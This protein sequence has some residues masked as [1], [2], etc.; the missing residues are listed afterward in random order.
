MTEKLTFRLSLTDSDNRTVQIDVNTVDDVP[1]DLLTAYQKLL[2][3]EETKRKAAIANDKKVD[4]QLKDIQ[5]QKQEEL[6]KPDE[7]ET[8]QDEESEDSGAA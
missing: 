8:E 4:K 5:K 1:I 6:K 3:D 7:E 2:A